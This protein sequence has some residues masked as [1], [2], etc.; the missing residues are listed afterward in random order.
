[1]GPSLTVASMKKIWQDIP[2]S[3]SRRELA[4][5]MRQSYW[6][7]SWSAWGKKK[8]RVNPVIT[9]I[10][11]PVNTLTSIFLVQSTILN[12]LLPSSFAF[13]WLDK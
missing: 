1:L 4:R 5:W 6:T 10:Y 3:Y 9:V 7:N 12:L 2:N 13:L 8:T 11:Q